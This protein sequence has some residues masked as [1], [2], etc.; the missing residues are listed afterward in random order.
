MY[1]TTRTH[2]RR[3][4]LQLPDDPWIS[5]NLLQSMFHGKNQSCCSY[6]AAI[7]YSNK[8][9]TLFIVATTVKEQA[10]TAVL[11]KDLCYFLVGESEL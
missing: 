8:H 10:T 11:P 1:G 9:H 3:G 6:I 5:M 4:L 7:A 2:A